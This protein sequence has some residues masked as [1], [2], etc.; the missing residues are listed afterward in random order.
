[1][2]VTFEPIGIIKTPFKKLEG[3][4]IQTKRAAGIKGEVHVDEKFVSGLD[5]LDGFSHI[6]LIY[7]FHKSAGYDLKTR[8]FL[9]KIKRGVFSTRA[10]RRPNPLGISVVKLL[11]IEKNVLYIENTDMLDGTPLLDIKPYISDFDLHETE[12]NG[13][14]TNKSG[15][16]KDTKSDNRFA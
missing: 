8:P 10:P 7:H 9:D 11:K 2:P 6:F 12:K 15:K 13:W 4:P 5:D 1:M 16:H 3:M 14:I